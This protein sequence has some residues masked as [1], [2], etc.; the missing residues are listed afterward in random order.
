MEE[1]QHKQDALNLQNTRLQ[2]A[3]SEAQ[4]YDRV[5]EKFIHDMAGQLAQPVD[6]VC[7]STYSIC[8]EYKTMTKTEMAKKQIDILQATE[9]I[10]SLLDQSFTAAK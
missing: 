3:Y 6:S 10:T 9:N 8:A 1:M 2:E 4:E 5:K 7:R